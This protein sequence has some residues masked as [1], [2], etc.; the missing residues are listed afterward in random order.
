MQ[1][2]TIDHDLTLGYAAAPLLYSPP[3]YPGLYRQRRGTSWVLGLSTLPYVNH[4]D[5]ILV[6]CVLWDRNIHGS[7]VSLSDCWI[8]ECWMLRYSAIKWWH[9][10][11]IKWSD[12]ELVMKQC[13]ME[14]N[15]MKHSVMKN[16]VMENSVME[17]QC[18][19]SG[20]RVLCD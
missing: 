18:Y 6:K 13:L 3:W 16:N 11:N 1:S 20:K 5:H 10:T 4:L 17:T 7:N 9:E 2:L 15:V 19:G 12:S 8:I 14:N